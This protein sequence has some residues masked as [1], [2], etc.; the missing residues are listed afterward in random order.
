[1]KRLL[2]LAA[3]LLLA[4]CGNEN[5]GSQREAKAACEQWKAQARGQLLVQVYDSKGR[6]SH[7][8]NDHG[9]RYCR[10]DPD[11]WNYVALGRAGYVHIPGKVY[12][13]RNGDVY[14]PWEIVKRFRY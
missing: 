2:A 8:S 4:G 3:V 9:V 12:D 14:P 10:H 1:M 5:Y 6:P 13:L 7:V 11:T